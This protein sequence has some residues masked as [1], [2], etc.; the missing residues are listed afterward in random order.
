MSLRREVESLDGCSNRLRLTRRRRGS[1]G[2]GLGR[3]ESA[4]I[5]GAR[6]GISEENGVGGCG[7]GGGG[8]PPSGSFEI[9]GD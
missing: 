3:R 6:V 2:F 5:G 9:G 7:G 8:G 4:R 1:R